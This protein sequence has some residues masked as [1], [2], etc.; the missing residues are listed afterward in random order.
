MPTLNRYEKVTCDNCGTQ[1]TKLKL[2]RHK[3][4][5]SGGTLHCSQC[6]NFFEISQICLNYHIARKHSVPRPL[7]T[8][9]CKLYQA[10]FPSF[11][12]VR[13]HKNTQHG[14]QMGFGASNIDAEVIVGDVDDQSLIEEMESCKHFLTDTKRENGRRRVF[15]FAMSSFDMSF[16]NDKLDYVFKELKC[17]AKVN[18]AFGFVEEWK[19]LR[20]ESVDTFTLTRTILLWRSRNM[21]VHKLIWPTWKTECR[22]WILLIFVPEKEPTQS[23]HLSNLQLQQFLLRYSKMYPCVV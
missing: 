5:C 21:C 10:D 14:P 18:L 19:T 8:Y 16:F 4:S 13:Q 11:F 1:T 3:K 20:M 7:K 6:L 9:S 17:A 23:G 2:A 22:K 12:A 15:N